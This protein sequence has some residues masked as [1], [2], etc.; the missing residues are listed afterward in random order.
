M[1]YRNCSFPLSN[2]MRNGLCA[3]LLVQSS[4]AAGVTSTTFDDFSDPTLPLQGWDMGRADITATH[5]SNVSDGGPAGAGDNFLQVISDGDTDGIIRAGERLTFFNRLQ[6]TGDYLSAGITAIAMDLKNFSSTE[7]LN[8][9]LAIE[10]GTTVDVGGLFATQ[11][12]ISLASGSDWTHVVFSLAPADLVPVSGNSGVTG[13]DVMAALG[14]VVELR[15]LNSATPDWAGTPVGATLGI[16]N[17]H[18]VPLP[19]ALGLFASGLAV[20]LTRRRRHHHPT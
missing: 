6:W 9:R 20:F 19:P 13:N 3:L 17:I 14:N 10:G 7:T 11:S 4:L 15:L 2:R 1:K 16:D 8:L 18:V 12:S 5:M